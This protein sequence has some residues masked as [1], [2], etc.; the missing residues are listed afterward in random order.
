MKLN[1]GI[2]F[3]SLSDCMNPDCSLQLLQPA[4]R[5]LGRNKEFNLLLT[6]IKIVTLVIIAGNSMNIST[7]FSAPLFSAV[8]GQ[9]TPVTDV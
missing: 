4:R 8:D 3:V 7:Y 9:R 1:E 5:N 6:L 2:K